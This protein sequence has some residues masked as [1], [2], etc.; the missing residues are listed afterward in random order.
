MNST[1]ENR[2]CIYS[3]EEFIFEENIYLEEHELMH[4]KGFISLA[5][6]LQV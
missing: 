1:K 4:R 6:T 3:K 5:T 2:F